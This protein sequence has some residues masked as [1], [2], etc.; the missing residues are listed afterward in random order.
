[1]RLMAADPGCSVELVFVE[2]LG[3]RTQQTEVPLHTIGGLGVFV[4]EIQQA[5]LR[6][7]A[8]MAAH[9]A[10]DLPS[11]TADGLHLA[12]FCQR[13]DPRD[14]LIGATLDE[15]ADR[16]HGRHGIRAAPGPA[17]RLPV[18]IS[19]SPSCAATS[20]PGS[21]RCRRAARS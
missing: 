5:V 4:K 16:G 13:R 12:A 7:D 6:G 20:T 1:M 17:R 3:D 18:P 10:K 19:S 11:S 9:S 2:T 21:A 14:A 15:L 8:D